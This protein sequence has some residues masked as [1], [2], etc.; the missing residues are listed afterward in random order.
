MFEVRE[1]EVYAQEEDR[2]TSPVGVS[3][4]LGLT[5]GVLIKLRTEREQKG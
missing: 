4:L 1:K 2:G 5:H 3:R